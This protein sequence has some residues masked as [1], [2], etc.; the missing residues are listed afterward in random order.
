MLLDPGL[1]Q[2]ML[3]FA[4][5]AVVQLTPSTMASDSHP[6]TG[7]DRPIPAAK[8]PVTSSSGS[9]S[10][11]FTTSS[12]LS[13]QSFLRS[14]DKTFAK[15]RV[16]RNARRNVST[17]S[18][19]TTDTGLSRWSQLS[20]LSLGEISN[21]SII[22]LPVYTV[23][24]NNGQVYQQ[25]MGRA[26][27]GKVRSGMVSLPRLQSLRQES[28]KVAAELRLRL[29]SV[30]D[31]ERRLLEAA[32]EGDSNTIELLLKKMESHIHVID[33]NM[34]TCLHHA[35]SRG[36]EATVR[37]LLDRGAEMV[38]TYWRKNTPLHVAAGGGREAT[39]RLLLDRGAEIGAKNST[40][41]PPLHV[42]A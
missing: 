3:S 8:H 18:F 6:P 4:S 37:L 42:A 41:N 28:V 11:I 15:T 1:S 19:N 22:C 16:Y 7:S 10:S 26:A 24:L 5:Q 34:Q 35:A 38:A 12:R 17:D 14:I 29:L 21:V 25:V 20:G 31:R 30:S 9:G 36:H 27:D 23:E 39:V 32:T 2:R 13:C 33:A 40:M